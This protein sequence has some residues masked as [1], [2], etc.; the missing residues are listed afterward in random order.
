LSQV[1]KK[2]ALI[3]QETPLS[4]SWRP[5]SSLFFLPAVRKAACASTFVTCSKAMLCS[6]VFNNFFFA[7]SLNSYAFKQKNFIRLPSGQSFNC[8]EYLRASLFLKQRTQPL[9]TKASSFFF[10]KK[11]I[12]VRGVAQN[13][14]DHKNGGSG[15]GGV[16]RGF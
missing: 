9:F 5:V 1:K 15:R 11:R 12:S 8:K 2:Q 16:L 13:A 6:L 14:V 7:V 10:K 3:Y 4:L